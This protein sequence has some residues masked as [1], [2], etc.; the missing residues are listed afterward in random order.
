MG[1]E[2]RDYMRE[3]RRREARLGSASW[4]DTKGRVEHGGLW[5]DTPIRGF[6]YRVR[7]RRTATAGRSGRLSWLLLLAAAAVLIPLGWEAKRSGWLP[8]AEPARAF[9]PSG[10]VAVSRTVDPLTATSRLRVATGPTDAVVQLFD[11]EGDD[12]ILSVFVRREDDVTV[13]VP[14]GTYRL[15]I[16]EGEKWHGPTRF[17]GS[18]TTYESAV[19]LMNFTSTSFRGVDL[20]RR[21]DGDLKTRVSWRRPQP[22]P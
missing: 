17:F 3:R 4:I 6:D 20:H 13:P 5:F 12:H 19:E 2:D 8:D 7:G 14:P 21:V 11:P 10:S 16:I 15:R 22:L 9:P 1:L 18:S